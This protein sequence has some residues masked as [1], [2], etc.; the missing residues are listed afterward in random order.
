MAK[1]KSDVEVL[2]TSAAISEAD[3]DE[4]EPETPN[5]VTDDNEDTQQEEDVDDDPAEE[6]VPDDEEEKEVDDEAQAE[7]DT[8]WI[9]ALAINY[10]LNT[11]YKYLKR[12]LLFVLQSEHVTGQKR[13]RWSE[14][15]Y[16]TFRKL[17]SA[18][19][20]MLV[21]YQSLGLDETN[22]RESAAALQDGL[23]Q[24]QKYR[25]ARYIAQR[26]VIR[27]RVYITSHLKMDHFQGLDIERI[28][29]IFD[30]TN[31]YEVRASLDSYLILAQIAQEDNPQML[32]MAHP[33]RGLTGIME[34]G[35]HLIGL[36]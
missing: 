36:F 24:S 28:K 15:L 26:L 4:E 18:V 21:V 3:Q 8:A 32:D 16:L 7:I 19:P 11:Y 5:S 1:T 34:L 12:T 9:K 14:D 17:T 31:L 25:L 2:K 10:P 27:Q 20:E 29:S 13:P 23:I 22:I 6:D 30:S 33:V 35:D